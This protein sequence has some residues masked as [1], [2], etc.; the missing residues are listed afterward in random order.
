M[1]QI[2][3]MNCIACPSIFSLPGIIISDKPN[4]N[5]YLSGILKQFGQHWATAWVAPP[6]KIK[7]RH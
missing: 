7:G 1:Q 3:I 4:V 2:E 5:N 6:K